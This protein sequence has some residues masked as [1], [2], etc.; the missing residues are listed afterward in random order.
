MWGF[1]ALKRLQLTA[2]QRLDVSA[3][4]W[5]SEAP[6]LTRLCSVSVLHMLLFQVFPTVTVSCYWNSSSCLLLCSRY[7]SLHFDVSLHYSCNKP[8]FQGDYCSLTCTIHTAV[9]FPSLI[10]HMNLKTSSVCERQHNTWEWRSGVQ[11]FFCFLYTLFYGFINVWDINY[12]F[13]VPE[14]NFSQVYLCS[15]SSLLSLVSPSSLLKA[16]CRPDIYIFQ[17]SWQRTR[18][19]KCSQTHMSRQVV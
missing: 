5:P 3:L 8:T 6:N 4:M 11:V 12:R 16:E 18:Q 14:H 19:H 15:R 13:A 1:F 9:S 7:Y 10:T 17:R 2:D